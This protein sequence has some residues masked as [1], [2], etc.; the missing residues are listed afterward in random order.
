MDRRDIIMSAIMSRLNS[1]DT[2]LTRKRSTNTQCEL[3]IASG[4]Q[5]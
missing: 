3:E 1:I 2:R 4:D 5:L